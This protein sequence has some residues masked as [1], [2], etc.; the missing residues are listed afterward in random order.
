MEGGAEGGEG[1]E[2]EQEEGGE[3]RE[4]YLQLSHHCEPDWPYVTGTG[5]CTAPPPHWLHRWDVR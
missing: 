2:Q 4:T 3:V 1:E 5:S